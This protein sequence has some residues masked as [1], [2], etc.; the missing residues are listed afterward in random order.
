MKRRQRGGNK[1]PPPGR[2]RIVAGKWR[3][4]FLDVADVPGLRPTGERIRETL[5]NWLAPRLQ[6]A[7]C[8]DLF[9]G[10]GVLGLEA[11]SRGAA[12]AVLVERSGR[13][14][15]ALEQSVGKL[16]AADAR[17]RSGDAWQFLRE[18]TPRPFDIVFLDPPYA[19]ARLGELCRLLVDRPWLADH[20]AVYFEQAASREPPA[21]PEGWEIRRE[22]TAGAVRYFLA[23]SGYCRSLQR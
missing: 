18:E 17:L 2:V 11:L 3:A 12:E 8:L 7:R 20:A 1:V 22:K 21:L 5:F 23:D 9:A 14:L 6:G 15:A 16:G 13:A 4:R 19:D 10:T